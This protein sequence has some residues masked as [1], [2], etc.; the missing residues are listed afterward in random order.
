MSGI[1]QHITRVNLKVQQLIKDYSS[2]KKENQ[3]LKVELSHTQ[4]LLKQKQEQV[5]LA[6]LRLEVSKASRGEM[7]DEEKK[8]FQKKRNA[9]PF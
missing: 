9:L 6:T 3:K 7:T 2:L 8:S 4:S 5:E 1:D